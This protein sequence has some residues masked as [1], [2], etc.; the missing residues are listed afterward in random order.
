[1]PTIVFLAN[2]L[3]REKRVEAPDGGNLVDICDDVFAP[4]PFS[5]RSASCAT[6]QVEVIDG[7]EWLEPPSAEERELLQLLQGPAENRLACQARV[8][9][10]IGLVRLRPI[11]S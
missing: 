11:G 4:I 3:G 1:V 2:V 10:G 8:R 7:A 5:C 9:P 6:C